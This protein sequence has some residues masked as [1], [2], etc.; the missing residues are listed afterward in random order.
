MVGERREKGQRRDAENSGIQESCFDGLQDRQYRKR[1]S[2]RHFQARPLK[3]EHNIIC[4]GGMRNPAKSV[5]RLTQFR[6]VGEKISS[7]WDEF[8]ESH[9]RALEVAANYGKADNVFEEA[10]GVVA[11]SIQREFDQGGRKTHSGQRKLGVHLPSP[12]G[13][14]GGVGRRSS[15]S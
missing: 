11:K 2:P 7:M 9:P 12:S 15:G 6:T 10:P 13:L 1:R 5:K 4:V 14:V 3:E 8:V